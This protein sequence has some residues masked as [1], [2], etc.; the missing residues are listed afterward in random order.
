MHAGGVEINHQDVLL[1]VAN[2]VWIWFRG[3]T[4]AVYDLD[5]MKHIERN[6]ARRAQKQGVSACGAARGSK[7]AEAL[8]CASSAS[9]S[10]HQHSC[11]QMKYNMS[12]T[13]TFSTE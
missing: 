4:E 7:D 9:R 1:P 12:M 5:Q 8:P 6:V 10:P 2:V 13:S 11:M 3:G